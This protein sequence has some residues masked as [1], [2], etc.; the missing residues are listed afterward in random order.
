M[1]YIV[2]RVKGGDDMILIKYIYIHV[3]GMY[4]YAVCYL[5]FLGKDHIG[6]GRI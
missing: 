2:V 4:Y 3:A 1:C 6:H 5:L